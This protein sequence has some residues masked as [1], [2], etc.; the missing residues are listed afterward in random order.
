LKIDKASA[1]DIPEIMRLIKKAVKAMNDSGLH[2]WDEQYPNREVISE[3]IEAGQL[4]KVIT[5]G[6]TAG[7]IVLSEQYWPEYN[8]LTWELDD[9]RPLIVHRLCIH[10]EYQGKG[11]AKRLMI[12]AEDFARENR[13]KS[14]R[15]DTSTLNAKALGLY[16]GLGY[17]RA[18]TVTFRTGLFQCFE[19]VID[20]E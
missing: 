2:Q 11:L 16:D 5:D 15:L 7:I 10:P 1:S 20:R 14:I 19:K 8:A 12:F 17:R 9:E 13:Y 3:D 6:N 18:G 4:Y